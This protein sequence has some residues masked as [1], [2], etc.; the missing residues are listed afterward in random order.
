MSINIIY[1]GEIGFDALAYGIDQHPANTNYF[2]QQIQSIS[3]TLTDVG[4]NFFSNAQTL[5]QQ[6]NNSETM[7][8]ARAALR[9]TASLFQPNQILSIFDIHKMQNAPLVM[10]RWIMA[11]PEARTLYHK[12]QIDGY[13]DSYQDMF[14]GVVGEQHYDYRRVM[15]SVVQDTVDL[16]GNES[17][18]VKYYP[19][20]LYEGDKELSHDDKVDIL[21]TY[22]ILEAFLAAGKEDPTSQYGSMM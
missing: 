21:S 22:E 15:D 2:Q 5:Y 8:I 4:Q 9:S 6:V 16:D 1:G 18:C 7:R 10:Q 13:S 3:N 12:Q 17:W 20:E 11:N 14:P 19:D